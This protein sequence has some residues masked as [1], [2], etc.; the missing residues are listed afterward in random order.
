MEKLEK[1]EEKYDEE[2]SAEKPEDKDNRNLRRVLHEE[3]GDDFMGYA[4]DVEKFRPVIVGGTDYKDIAQA[5]IY[6]NIDSKAE[7]N[8]EERMEEVFDDQVDKMIIVADE[9]D[10]RERQ[11]EI[12]A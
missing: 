7:L 8:E 9:K 12:D 4:E 3:I 5:L 10:I 6:H 2:G 11:R 1:K